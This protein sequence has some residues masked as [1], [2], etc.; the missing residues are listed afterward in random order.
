MAVLAEYM[1]TKRLEVQK[2]NSTSVI[3]ACSKNLFQHLP[4]FCLKPNS[5]WTFRFLS[6]T[7]EAP[8]IP[9][10]KL[11]ITSALLFYTESGLRIRTSTHLTVISEKGI[12]VL[13]LIARKNWLN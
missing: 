3:L 12:I 2:Q 11:Y 1:Y 13:P 7:A 10:W 5:S 8:N 9:F 4:I 6:T